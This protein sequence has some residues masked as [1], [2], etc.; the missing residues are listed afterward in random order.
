MTVRVS[1]A[2]CVLE[3][4]RAAA[5]EAF[6]KA[7]KPREGAVRP[8]GRSLVAGARGAT[9]VLDAETGAEKERL[10]GHL[11]SICSVAYMGDGAHLGHPPEETGLPR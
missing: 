1:G 5:E 6:V 7:V 11:G 8:E 3:A 4:A 2:V 10:H 9:I